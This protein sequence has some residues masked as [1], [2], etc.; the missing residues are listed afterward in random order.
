M[1]YYLTLR[2]TRETSADGSPIPSPDM[3]TRSLLALLLLSA[4]AAAQTQVWQD[5]FN[6]G[7]VDPAWTVTFNPLQFWNTGE[8]GGYYNFDGLTAP[9]GAFNE[10]FELQQD[11]TDVSGAFTFETAF[12]WNDNPFAPS[13]GYSVLD[14][15]ME[16]LDASGNVIVRVYLNDT[17][18]ATGMTEV[19]VEAG[20]G[21]STMG[22]LP[23]AG[24]MVV[25]VVRDGADNVSYT[26]TG[27]AG[28]YSGSVGTSAGTVD[29]VKFYTTG[30][31]L[32]VGLPPLGEARVDQLTVFAGTPG[33]SLSASGAPGGSMTFDMGGF[34]ASGQIAV[35]YGPAGTFAV[36]G[37]PCA[38]LVVDLQPLNFPPVSALI[39]LAADASGNAQL[40]QNVPA[41]GAGLSVQAVDAATCTASNVIVL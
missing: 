32:G 18:T 2:P 14:T 8:F 37:G 1:T 34:T 27:S 35:V 6:D 38:G 5:D 4:P 11:I 26:A 40:T 29:D 20:A 16:L 13:A 33:P 25:T 9:F 3:N 15:K 39:T 12:E 24:D 21:S 19:I 36:P 28:T 23:D 10:T 31:S 7:V 17:S 41:A 22:T 30:V